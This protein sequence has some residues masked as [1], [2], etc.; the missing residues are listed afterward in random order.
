MLR[1]QHAIPIPPQSQIPGWRGRIPREAHSACNTPGSLRHRTDGGQPTHPRWSDCTG[2]NR[3]TGISPPPD[4]SRT[5][6]YVALLLRLNSRLTFCF[7]R[8]V[9]IAPNA[10]DSI[11]SAHAQDDRADHSLFRNTR[12]AHQ[13]LEP[14]RFAESGADVVGVVAGLELYAWPGPDGPDLRQPHPHARVCNQSA[15]RRPG[16]A[17]RSPRPDHRQESRAGEETSV[18]LSL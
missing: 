6:S 13:H 11:S 2:R 15:L 3:S 7:D 10:R 5:K 1:P 8:K 4:H 18:G 16:H 12:S 9:R 14:R 17:G